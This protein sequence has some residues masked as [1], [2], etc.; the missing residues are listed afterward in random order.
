MASTTFD[1]LLAILLPLTICIVAYRLKDQLWNNQ[2]LKD[3][4]WP[5]K[6]NASLFGLER[7]Y[8]SF[9]HYESMSKNEI[10][11]MKNAY[12]KLGRAHKNLGHKLGYP[13]KLQKLHDATGMNGYIADS[14]AEA[15]G[16]FLSGVFLN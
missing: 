2:E 3:L 6:N 5:P 14:V 16:A 7:A 10:A 11:R 8:Y 12:G 1:L 13:T 15:R 9:L 4:I